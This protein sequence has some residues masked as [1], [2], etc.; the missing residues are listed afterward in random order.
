MR[1]YRLVYRSGAAA[2]G[3][4]LHVLPVEPQAKP[5]GLRFSRSQLCMAIDAAA[6]LPEDV[7]ACGELALGMLRAL[8]PP[9][10][11]TLRLCDVVLPHPTEGT[12]ERVTHS[13]SMGPPSGCTLSALEQ[14]RAGESTPLLTSHASWR[15]C[16]RCVAGSAVPGSH[17]WDWIC[18]NPRP[19][20]CDLQA[21]QQSTG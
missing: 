14:F 5:P 21:W 1:S 10:Q 7:L 4:V 11:L 9:A 17:I 8:R 19:P 6:L 16:A 2:S 13:A 12:P 20:Q 15:R 3:E 18:S